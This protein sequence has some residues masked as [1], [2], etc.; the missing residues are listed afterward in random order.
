MTAA[1]N[2]VVVTG[3]T[4]GIGAGCVSALQREGRYVIGIDRAEKSSADEHHRVDLGDASCGELIA[5]AVDDRDVCGLVNNAA[6]ALY[7][8]A[9][10][11]TAL[12]WD[13]VLSVNLRSPFLISCALL[14]SLRRTSGAIVN[15]AS[16]HASATSIGVSAYAAS[17]GG[18]VALTRALAVEWAAEGVRVNCVV[19]GAVDTPM[20]REG[21]FRTGADPE[22]LGA[23]HPLRR[24]GTAADVAGAVAFLLSDAASFITGAS[25]VVDGGALAHLS[26]E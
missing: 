4:R 18:L 10:S 25:L 11:T 1:D 14:P 26:T 13:A 19:P 23:R 20:L 8:P 21:L 24:L 22:T 15:I 5:T 3:A 7:E 16:V 6:F 2:P 17:K 12:M 9:E